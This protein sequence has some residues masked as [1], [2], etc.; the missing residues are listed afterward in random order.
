MESGAFAITEKPIFSLQMTILRERLLHFA[1]SAFLVAETWSADY[2]KGEC[3]M[4]YED[5]G[6]AF[7]AP[8]LPY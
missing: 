3:G 4:R 1:L 2:G 7:L 5:R 8:D 6:N